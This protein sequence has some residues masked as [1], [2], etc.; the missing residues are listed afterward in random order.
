MKL[1]YLWLNEFVKIDDIEPSEVALKLTMCTSEIEKVEEVGD[2]LQN[3]VVG[4]II[5]VKPHPDSSHLFLTRID[6]GTQI[7]NI[8]SGAPNTINGTFV[9]VALIGARLPGGMEVKKAKLR[10]F[11]SWGVVCSEKEL[12]VSEDHSGLWILDGEGLQLSALKP[13]TPISKLFPTKDWI[14]EIDNKSIT[15]RPDLWGHY[16]FARELASI[17]KRALR[18]LYS[19]EEIDAVLEARG[20]S[21]IEVEVKDPTLCPRY[22]AIALGGFRIKKSPYL[23]RRRLYTLGIRPINNIVDI[24]NYVMLETGQPLHAFDAEKISGRRIIVRRAFEDEEIFTLDGTFRKIG[25]QT[26]LIADPEKGVAIAGVMGGLD[27]EISDRTEEIII[28]AANFNPVS[29]RRTA[30]RLGLRT[31]ASNRFEKSLDPELTFYGIVGSVSLVMRTIPGSKFTSPLVDV[32]PGKKGKKVIVVSCSWIEK[33]LG[34]DIR[35]ER[36]KEIL[37]SLHFGVD[38][39][40]DDVLKVTVPSFR[41]SKDVS[42]PQDIVEEVGRMYGYDSIQPVLP[43]FES[44][45]PPRDSSLSFMRIVKRILAGDLGFTEVY[46]YSFHDDSFLNLFYDPDVRF[47]TIQNPIS[48]SMSRLRRSLIPGLFG[49]IEKNIAAFDEFSV[50]EAGSV[51]NPCA[52][53]EKSGLPDERLRVCALILKKVGK[54]PVFFDMKG[55]IDSLLQKLCIHDVDHV[56]F[57]RARYYPQKISLEDFGRD[58]NYHPGRRSLLCRGQTCFGIISELNPGL[59]K[60]I[61]VDFHTTRVAVCELDLLLLEGVYSVEKLKLMYRPLPRFPEV[62]LAHAVVVDEDVPVKEVRDFISSHD[63][64]L[65]ERVELF[66]VYRGTPLPPGKKNLAFNIYYRSDE[67]T[68]TEKEAIAVH[69]EIAEKIKKRG[70]EL[71]R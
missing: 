40:R 66:D 69:E 19:K 11:E 54:R 9:P 7:L 32:Y 41:A 23:L 60:S 4:K 67:R 5:D 18:P 10:G 62:V 17:F 14:I 33:M 42:I 59:L 49:I 53:G 37:R 29:I 38:E 61:G 1:S 57:E 50:F 52:L 48:S 20:D 3:V 30:A 65:I 43:S 25:S 22:N 55:R 45:P 63:S 21:E 35:K 39:D 2:E 16:G 27:S 26:L 15:H 56:D 70:W 58:V 34:K 64:E 12:G 24:T 51:Y 68:L 6:A 13:G 47:V 46:T 36:I 31:E 8:I 44:T 28:E 71:R